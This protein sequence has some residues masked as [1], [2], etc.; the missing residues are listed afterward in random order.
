VGTQIGREGRYSGLTSM[1]D[2][3]PFAV[4]KDFVDRLVG[5][6]CVQRVSYRSVQ[7]RKIEIFLSVD[8]AS[9]PSQLDMHFA[10]KYLVTRYPFYSFGFKQLQSRVPIP[11]QSTVMLDRRF[12]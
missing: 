5:V 1:R 11:E 8:N 12:R 4:C 2:D 10:K 6:E 7:P 9:Y 3:S